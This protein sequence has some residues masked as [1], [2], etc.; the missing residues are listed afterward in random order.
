MNEKER[1]A[2]KVKEI[3]GLREDVARAGRALAFVEGPFW[4][5]DVEPFL[6]EQQRLAKEAQHYSPGMSMP[7][8]DQLGLKVAYFSGA[9][10]AIARIAA[11][12]DDFIRQ[13]QEA[14]QTLKDRGVEI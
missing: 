5:K 7:T 6:V 12:I 13:G 14:R 8:L 3:E 11:R 9:D 2:E 4:T 1:E 10:D